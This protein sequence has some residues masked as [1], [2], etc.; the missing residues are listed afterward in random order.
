MSSYELGYKGKMIRKKYDLINSCYHCCK[1][2]DT[3]LITYKY[4]LPYDDT[5]YAKR[6]YKEIL[7]CES[8]WNKIQLTSLTKEKF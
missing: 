6:T 2:P 8:C 5:S 4:V 7:L 3:T 1:K